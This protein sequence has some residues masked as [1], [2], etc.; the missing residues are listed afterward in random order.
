MT[1]TVAAL[2]AVGLVVAP[3]AHATVI[4]FESIPDGGFACFGGGCAFPDSPFVEDGFVLT[5]EGF[6]SWDTDNLSYTGS[7]AL[8]NDFIGDPT[9][10]TVSGGGA[11]TLSSIDLSEAYFTGG[12][13][14]VTFVGTRSNSSTLSV[15]FAL[16]GVFGNETFVFSA[17]WTDLVSVSWNQD[18]EF[19]QFDNIVVEAAGAVPEP[20]PLT[21][22]G[23]GALS[24]GLAARRR[25][26]G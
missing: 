18:P 4:D 8:F 7:R 15:T 23:L 2:F 16:D 11:F 20:G 3:A 19:H 9:F 5:A 22:F 1:R 6:A 26:R 10:L 25:A 14:S 13:V 12:P 21:L 24:L 17:A